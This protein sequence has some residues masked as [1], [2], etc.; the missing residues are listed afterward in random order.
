MEL[1]GGLYSYKDE[2][3]NKSYIDH[4][5]FSVLPYKLSRK[6]YNKL[7]DAQSIWMKLFPKIVADKE[8]INTIFSNLVKDDD[9]VGSLLRIYNEI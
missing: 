4:V 8:F 9:F 1:A 7:V 5:P 2:N 3:S 6:E